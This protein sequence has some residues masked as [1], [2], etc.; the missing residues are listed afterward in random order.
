MELFRSLPYL[1]LLVLLLHDSALAQ[2]QQNPLTLHGGSVLA[3]AGHDCVAVAVDRRFASG[4][5]LI[6]IAP[7]PVLALSADQMVACTGLEGDIHTVQAQIRAEFAAPGAGRTPAALAS[8]MSHI[9]YRRRGSPYYVEPIVVG[10]EKVTEKRNHAT[11]AV[12]D[13]EEEEELT[14]VNSD[15][16]NENSFTEHDSPKVNYRPYM[17]SLDCIGAR[18]L[19]ESFC[20]SG[21]AS[22]YGAAE[23]AWRPG[24]TSSELL[25]VM[26]RVWMSALERDTLSGYGAVIYLMTREG[27][28]EYHVA[29]RND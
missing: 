7:R 27:I 26:A 10:L 8:M 20:C 22:L 13:Q 17:C 6:H 9:L 25:R 28:R 18:S 2:E 1:A 3:M 21:T 19:S 24:L 29:G 16:V 4:S 11:T 14:D 23:A 5:S 15:D 12:N